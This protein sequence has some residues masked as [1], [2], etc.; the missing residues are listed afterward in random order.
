MRQLAGDPGLG[1][2][3]CTAASPGVAPQ[4]R[5]NGRGSS[6]KTPPAHCR[7]FS[8]S[9]ACAGSWGPTFHA[10]SSTRRSVGS[11]FK[12]LHSFST[13][14]KDWQRGSLTVICRVGKGTAE[15]WQHTV[16]STEGLAAARKWADKDG[17][18]RGILM[19][20]PGKAAGCGM[21]SAC[22]EATQQ[23]SVRK[24]MQQKAAG[25]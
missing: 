22:K 20:R 11:T 3:C 10:S 21:A 17:K 5:C 23:R 7:D 25:W 19:P 15:G 9:M 18:Q 13:P 6:G 14:A 4:Q 16:G 24:Q 1:H 2:A 12:S 8:D